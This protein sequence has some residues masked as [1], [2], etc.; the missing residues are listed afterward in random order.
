MSKEARE[1]LRGAG[2]VAALALGAALLA[3]GDAQAGIKY[4][5]DGAIQNARGGWDLP[6]QGACPADAT[7]TTRPECLA[8]RYKAA[9]SAECTALGATGQYS[10]STGACNDTVNNTETLCKKAVDR[11]WNAAAG[12]CAIV[13]EDDDRNDVSCMKHGGTWVTSGTCT[14]GW[15]MPPR[16]DPAYGPGGLWSSNGA[17]DQCLRCHNNRTQYNGPRVRD[18]E[19]TLMM[20]HKNMVR[21]VDKTFKPWGGPPFACTGFP[22]YKTQEDCV[23]GGGTWDPTIYP[24]DDTGNAFNWNSNKITVGTKSYDLKW[25][26][27]DW[28]GR[29]P[30]AIYTGAD[31]NNMSYSCG[32][33]HTTGWTSD[34]GSTPKATKHPESDFPGITWTGSGTTGQVKLGGGVAGDPNT[35]SSW[36]EWGITCS[37]CHMSAVDD[38]SVPPTF[39]A[40]GG[41]SSHHNNLTSPNANNGA[42]TD[43]RWTGGPTGT[44]FEDHCKNN[45]GTFLTACSVNPTPGVCTVAANTKTKCEAVAGATWVP[46]AG[47]CSNAF[48]TSSTACT[49]NGNTWTDGWCKTAD[50]Q[51][52]CTGG[53]GDAAK[54]WRLNGSQASCQIAG[55]AWTFSKCSVE[56]FCNKGACS[57]AK[58]A[59]AVDCTDAGATWTAI[60]TKARCDEVGG[61]FAFATDII[62]CDDAGGKWTG[63]NTNRG[64]VITRLCM[65]CHRQEANGLPHTNGTCSNGTSTT[66]GACVVAGGT[67]TDTGNGLPVIAGPY[68]GTVTFPSHPAGNQFLNSPH[69][70][71]V[72]KW[73]DIATGKFDFSPN[74]KYKS[75]FMDF[76]E[77]RNT[78]NGCTGCHDVHT[79]TVAGEK[80]FRAECNECH[81]IKSAD[82][83]QHP[84]GAGTPFE[85]MDHEPMAPCVTCHMPEGQHLW[86][87]NTDNNYSTFALPQAINANTPA[88]TAPDGSYTNAVWVDLDAACGQCHGGGNSNVK[89]TGTIAAGSASLTVAS[90]TG[91]LAGERVIVA[92]AGAYA[93]P[94]V[95]YDFHTYIKAIAGNVVTLAGNATHAVTNAAVTMNPTANGAPYKSKVTLSLLAPGIH[96]DPN[97]KF[98][99]KQGANELTVA[100]DASATKC[101]GKLSNCTA[102]DWN[103][104]DGT[105]HGSGVTAT[106]TY[107]SA[108]NYTITLTVTQSSVGDASTTRT[109]AAK[110]I[111]GAPVV[112]GSCVANYPTWSTEC[113]VT[114]PAS[115]YKTVSIN[116]GDGSAAD[117]KSDA[118]AGPLAFKHSFQ[119]PANY[120]IAATVT[121]AAGMSTTATVGTMAQATF[122][123]EM[124]GISGKVY[125]A[126]GTVP[127]A[128][129]SIDVMSGTTKVGNI[130]SG[131]DGS[132]E[133]GR[134]KPGTYTFNVTKYGQKFTKPFG[135]YTIGPSL[136]NQN[137]VA[138]P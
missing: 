100:V 1:R 124:P 74:A 30:R 43:I 78:G 104:G 28:L 38:T 102:F 44:S 2:W 26:Y 50:A 130:L 41:M 65:D 53:T 86:R 32:R 67:W 136:T 93:S 72:G 18:T 34:P 25:V 6:K 109:F 80:P 61:Q 122:I 91:L 82:K 115:G 52:A 116:W 101:S 76:G 106:H 77:A 129:A 110:A 46:L 120:A 60:R 85:K 58:Y 64:Q 11:Y 123:A 10:W 48:F 8:R 137:L 92:G 15:V 113:T 9:T 16:D 71:F 27:G 33:C 3:P 114:V 59:N 40:P 23:H 107:K 125:Q 138:E 36:D 55:A 19:D 68:H 22:N 66:Q 21:P 117:T 20:G 29:L 81:H 121:D 87:I 112:T 75:A 133:T 88:A 83:I 98:D 54:T 14:A 47:W 97:P 69:A 7:A 24:S 118:A 94:G 57:D 95:W 128:F 111:T 96:N 35:M 131:K 135:P 17:G 73:D 4:L 5:G 90:A 42:C 37:R 99:A 79:S 13:M 127:V 134:L 62:R 31:L 70:K 126:G 51:A 108:A 105:V 12:V 89:T 84:K 103:W 49:A 63:N 119:K 56:G 45:G 39:R 132:Y